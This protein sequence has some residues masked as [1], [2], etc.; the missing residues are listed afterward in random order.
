MREENDGEKRTMVG[1]LPAI[2]KVTNEESQVL[3]PVSAGEISPSM[4]LI[5]SSANLLFKTMSNVKV[6]EVYDIE[7]ICKC[8]KEI[9]KLMRLK[10]DVLKEGRKK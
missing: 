6:E 8:A 1:M 5:D 3:L 10:Y 9:E 2:K 4:S 7:S